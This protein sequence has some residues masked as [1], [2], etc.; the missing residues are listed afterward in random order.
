MTRP[1]SKKQKRKTLVKML[2]NAMYEHEDGA[3][4]DDLAEGLADVLMETVFLEA[5][6]S[7]LFWDQYYSLQRENKRLK[8]RNYALAKKYKRIRDEENT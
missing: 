4:F 3:T 8:M 6:N 1:S 5:D 2:V 7:S